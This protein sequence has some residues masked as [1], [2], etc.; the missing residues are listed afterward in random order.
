M[1]QGL[2]RRE[3]PA[4]VLDGDEAARAGLD[5]GVPLA[6]RKKVGTESP[7]A[8]LYRFDRDAHDCARGEEGEEGVVRV[9]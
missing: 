5:E 2:T 4:A 3:G 7:N 9:V 6:A 8:V 1:R